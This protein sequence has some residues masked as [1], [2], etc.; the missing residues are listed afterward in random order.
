MSLS[1]FHGVVFNEKAFI[2]FP[3]EPLFKIENRLVERSSLFC[4]IFLFS[5]YEGTD[6]IFIT[7]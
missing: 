5:T 3:Q 1:Q 4:V 2:L 7:G 6:L